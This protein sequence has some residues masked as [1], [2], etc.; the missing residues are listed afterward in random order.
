MKLELKSKNLELTSAIKEYIEIKIGHLSKFVEKIENKGTEVL[1][2]VEIGRI[3]NHH[4]KGDVYRVE[5]NIDAPQNI[6]RIEEE[7]SDVR[8]LLD[9]V[10]NKL[11]QLLVKYKEKKEE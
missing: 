8:A 2:R 7:G 3:S 10:Q 9:L 5:V 11:K 4:G 1:A 6:V